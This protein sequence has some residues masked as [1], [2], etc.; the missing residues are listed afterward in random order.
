MILLFASCPGGARAGDFVYVVEDAGAGGYEAF[1]D[2]CRLQDGRLMAVYYAGYGHVA[3]PNEDLPKGGRICYSISE[4][5]GNSWGPAQVLYDGP[6]DDRD[7]SIAQLK[8]GTL[9]CNFFSLR[10]T[11]DPKEERHP[12]TGLGSWYVKSTDA[13]KTWSDPVQLTETYYCSSPV[14]ELSDGTLVLGLYQQI[15]GEAWGAVLRSEDGGKTW[16]KEIDIDNGGMKLDAETDIIELKD[17]RL[18]AAQ[19]NHM[20]YSISEDKGKTWSVSQP[21]GFPGDAPYL[22]RTVDDIIIVAHRTPKT[23]L[24]YSLDECATWSENVPVDEAFHGAYPSMVNLEDGSVL[25][26]YYEE[27]EG[28]SI[29]ARRFKASKDGIE[30]LPI[31]KE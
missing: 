8:D 5:E 21:M 17:G 18:Y 25:I 28:S 4:D 23:S 26:V 11:G 2:V 12:W 30:W 6:D 24:H 10:K 16:G 14:R 22:H 1:P 9:I 13:G 27:G 29:R 19:R 31:G 3:L 20:G 7:P 15:E